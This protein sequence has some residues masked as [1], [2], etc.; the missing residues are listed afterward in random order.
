MARALK[1]HPKGPHL[2]GR[3]RA[4]WDALSGRV[5]SLRSPPRALPSATMGSPFRRDLSATFL[6]ELNRANH[7]CRTS[8]NRSA[9]GRSEAQAGFFSVPQH[10]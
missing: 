3:R 2:T 5:I 10:C 6:F 7:V 4:A 9:L 8:R 1:G